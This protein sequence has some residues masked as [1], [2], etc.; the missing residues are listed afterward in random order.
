MVYQ[1]VSLFS[2]NDETDVQTSYAKLSMIKIYVLQLEENKYY[3]GQTKNSDQRLKFHLKGKL[4]SE[5]TKKYKP[6]KVIEER[7]TEFDKIED[8]LILENSTTIE[9][10]KKFGWRNVRGGDFCTLNEEKLRF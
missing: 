8:A 4:G 5:W 6:I 1:I 9:Y 10:M 7:E 3:V 2:I